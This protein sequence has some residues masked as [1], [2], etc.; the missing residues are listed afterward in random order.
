[1]RVVG[2]GGEEGTWTGRQGGE[3]GKRKRKERICKKKRIV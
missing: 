2:K 1:M 3:K